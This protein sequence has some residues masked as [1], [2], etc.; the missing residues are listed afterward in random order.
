MHF[1]SATSKSKLS[2][3]HPYLRTLMNRA[4]LISPY[5]FTIICGARNQQDQDAAFAAGKSEKQW[6]DGNHNA[7][8]AIA[9]IERPKWPSLPFWSNAIDI[10]PF[11]LDWQDTSR[12]YVLAG[13]IL[14]TFEE[15]RRESEIPLAA[16]IRWGGDWDSD[17]EFKDQSFDDLGHFE[18]VMPKELERISL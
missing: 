7:L 13:V 10:A 18:L 16:K 8:V 5:D 1:F 3:C 17:G 9:P 14:A 2:D 6:P 12:F 11:P 4:I 15:L